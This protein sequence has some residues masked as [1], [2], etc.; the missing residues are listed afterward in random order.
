MVINAKD[1]NKAGQG[2]V[3]VGGSTTGFRKVDSESLTGNVMA[4]DVFAEAKCVSLQVLPSSL[5]LKNVGYSHTPQSKIW[6]LSQWSS[7]FHL[8]VAMAT[9]SLQ[10]LTALGITSQMPQQTPLRGANPT[11]SR[12]S[13]ALVTGL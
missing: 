8:V 3:T 2:I 13:L 4:V 6:G 12:L 1:T 5:C 10:A 11:G 9:V 7:V